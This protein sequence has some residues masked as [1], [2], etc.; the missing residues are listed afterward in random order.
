M[1][2]SLEERSRVLEHVWRSELS[3]F[4]RAHHADAVRDLPLQS[5]S[6]W[7]RVPLLSREDIAQAPFW[8]RLYVPRK[9]VNVVRPTSGTSGRG[10]TLSP[11]ANYL[12]TV[13]DDFTALG[14]RVTGGLFF[15]NPPHMF[16][17]HLSAAVPIVGGDP[18]HPEI[19]AA[20][21]KRAGVN[22]LVC[23]PHLVGKIEHA[24]RSSGLAGD[25]LG[26]YPFGEYLS[27]TVREHFAKLFPNAFFINTYG[28]SELYGEVAT[29][30]FSAKDY[31]AE[32]YRLRE[33][34]DNFL[35]LFGENGTTAT[36]EIGQEGEL[37]V[38]SLGPA[39]QAFP[40]IRYR[41]GDSVRVLSREGPGR[42][43]FEVL[44]RAEMDKLKLNGGVL[45]PEEVDRVL[46]AVLGG[47]FAGRY[48][49]ELIVDTGESGMLQRGII[50]LPEVVLPG[51]GAE[52]ETA[53]RIASMLHVTPSRTYA[54]GIRDGLYG[55][56]SF[57]KLVESRS[58]S[59]TRRMLDNTR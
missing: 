15:M 40:M 11:R 45:W 53:A 57:Q 42:F 9:D 12:S 19:S 44:G 41:T 38:T 13:L 8:D 39:A 37:I 5:E 28:A 23:Y 7:V 14:I 16:E 17:A 3:T 25:L 1:K 32:G 48:L 4:Y 59:K 26:V 31:E 55:P 50:H 18:M 33:P 58:I 56:L 47:S 54:D 27:R 22:I 21:A 10:I 52:T 49:F 36:P 35:E 43:V 24:L 51:R 46:S 29:V 30:K 6:D 20:L 34:P 2:S